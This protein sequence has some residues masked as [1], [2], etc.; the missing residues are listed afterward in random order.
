MKAHQRQI[1]DGFEIELPV[2]EN[3]PDNAP[4]D[5]GTGTEE[6]GEYGVAVEEG[7]PEEAEPPRY[8]VFLYN[9][10]YTTMEFVVEVLT[11]FF[12][13]NQDRAV[14]VMLKIHNDGKGVAGIYPFEIAETK[15]AQVVDYSR[16]KGF[17]LKCQAE[18]VD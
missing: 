3:D 14:Q 16:S 2:F 1:A 4:G 15:V 10:D 17:P 13:L 11:R 12:R 6:Q 5:G 9:D 7:Y 18:P 8:G